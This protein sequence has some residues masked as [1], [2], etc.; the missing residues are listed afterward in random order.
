[1]AYRLERRAHTQKSAIGSKKSNVTFDSICAIKILCTGFVT[2]VLWCFDFGEWENENKNDWIIRS[3]CCVPSSIKFR[4]QMRH[5]LSVLRFCYCCCCFV[6]SHRHSVGR[7]EDVKN[8]N[9][10]TTFSNHKQEMNPR[11]QITMNVCK[12]L[13][14]HRCVRYMSMNIVLHFR[15]FQMCTA[16]NNNA[17]MGNSISGQPKTKKK[18][19]KNEEG[20]K[21]T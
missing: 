6:P 20:K 12:S 1:M 19:D 11:S 9:D 21:E 2:S 14:G 17:L 8:E 5:S 15:W 18:S 10:G 7:D 13:N 3:C 4:H 16:Q